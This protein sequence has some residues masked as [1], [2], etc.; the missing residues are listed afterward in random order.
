[1]GPKKLRWPRAPHALNPFLGIGKSASRR[2]ICDQRWT[3]SSA[4]SIPDDASATFCALATFQKWPVKVRKV[5][6]ELPK[7][8]RQETFGKSLHQPVGK[9]FFTVV[10]VVSSAKCLVS[11]SYVHNVAMIRQTFC[12]QAMAGFICPGAQCS[13]CYS[14][15]DDFLRHIR[16]DHNSFQYL[17]VLRCRIGDCESR[18]SSY[19]AYNVHL[20]RKHTKDLDDKLAGSSN[21]QFMVDSFDTV[22]SNVLENSLSHNS[23]E[24]SRIQTFKRKFFLLFLSCREE[25]ALPAQVIQSIF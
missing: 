7:T 24:N 1:M 17:G 22:C 15:K 20:K 16:L 6:G 25:H 13:N 12:V 18:V 8:Y 2:L 10:K 19:K 11:L 9:V 21:E 3:D 4:H 14:E 23:G 5:W